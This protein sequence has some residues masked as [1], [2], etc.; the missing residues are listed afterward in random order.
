M[1]ISLDPEGKIL[2]WNRAAERITGLS[3]EQAKGE[4]LASLCVSNQQ[5]TMTTML[6]TVASG[7]KVHSSEVHLRTA[8]G[9]Q[10][11]VAWSC[12]AMRDD[13]G[14]VVRLHSTWSLI[15]GLLRRL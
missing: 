4:H 2:T 7:E 15:N 10:V 14:D 3:H 9:D 13:I 5:G 8:S 1:V 11:P 12:S 6:Q